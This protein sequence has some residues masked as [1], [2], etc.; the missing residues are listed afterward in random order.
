MSRLTIRIDFGPDAAFGPGKARL[1]EL[2]DEKGSIRRAAVSMGMSYRRA[3]LLL[4]DI[5][6]LIGM[7]AVQ[8]RTGGLHGGGTA[9]SAKGR[10]MLERYRTIERRAAQSVSADLAYLARLTGKARSHRNGGRP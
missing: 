5:E 8:T 6:N 4:Q 9:L 2:V 3:W 7:P 10:A 1:L